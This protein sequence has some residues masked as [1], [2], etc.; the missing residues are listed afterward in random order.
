MIG[1]RHV[2]ARGPR[3]ALRHWRL[4]VPLYLV[5]LVLG[6]LQTW[7][8]LA[9]GREGLRNPFLGELA[10]RVPPEALAAWMNASMPVRMPRPN[11][12]EGPLSA[13]DMPRTTSRWTSLIDAERT[14]FPT[15]MTAP[16]HAAKIQCR[17]FI[18]R[19]PQR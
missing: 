18:S 14:G 15:R 3:A 13:A 12:P 17:I 4:L 11:W 19:T 10:D 8:L 7:P 16:I 9:A 6:L 2:V 1:F 5:G